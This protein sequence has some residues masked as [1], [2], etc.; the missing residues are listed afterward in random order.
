M[1]LSYDTKSTSKKRKK[2]KSDFIKIKNF[3]AREDI[4]K[5]KRPIAWEKIHTCKSHI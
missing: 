3:C 5:V 1:G 2:N 4:I